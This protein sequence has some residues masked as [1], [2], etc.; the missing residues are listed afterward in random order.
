[1]GITREQMIDALVAHVTDAVFECGAAEWIEARLRFG[2]SFAPYTERTD[3]EIESEY[4]E[5]FGEDEDEDEGVQ[6]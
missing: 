4:R 3:A 1:M 2:T 5:I 6:S